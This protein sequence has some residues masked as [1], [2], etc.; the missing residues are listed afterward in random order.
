MKLNP[1]LDLSAVSYKETDDV[2]RY[3]QQFYTIYYNN[4]RRQ[5]KKRTFC[6][7]DETCFETYCS[8][9]SRKFMSDRII[10][11]RAV[12]ARQPK[13]VDFVVRLV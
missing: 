2:I 8:Q 10:G 12:K 9:L 11:I 3:S 1:K 4:I 6:I 13:M 5:Q 7:Y